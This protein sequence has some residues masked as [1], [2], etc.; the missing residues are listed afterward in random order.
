MFLKIDELSNYMKQKIVYTT[1]LPKSAD[2]LND[3]GVAMCPQSGMVRGSRF[4]LR[5]SFI[6][7]YLIDAFIQSKCTLAA[8]V[9]AL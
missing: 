6:L 5:C 8:F 3:A 2:R 9:F 4:Q 7:E 1:S